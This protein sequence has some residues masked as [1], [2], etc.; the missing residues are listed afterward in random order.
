MS[1]L[2]NKNKI[3]EILINDKNIKW[4]M[5]INKVY[6]DN[7]YCFCFN[8]ELIDTD[9]RF[10]IVKLKN[11]NYVIK[12]T[13][14]NKASL[15]YNNAVEMERLLANID[16][17]GYKIIPVIPIIVTVKSDS[18]VITEY[19]GFTLQESL[20]D[21]K[22]S[23]TIPLFLFQKIFYELLT[24]GLIYRGFIPRN[25]ILKSK[26]IYM[27]DFED[28]DLRQCKDS[29]SIDL[30]Y[31]TNF[32]LNWQYFYQKEDLI[33]IIKK[34]NFVIK[35]TKELLPFEKCYKDILNI[36]DD[37]YSLR[38]KIFN[39]VINSEKPSLKHSS[40]KYKIM[41]NDLVHIM[42]DLFGDY[43]DV[44]IDLLFD[45]MRTKDESDFEM[46]L[47]LC[48]YYIKLNYNNLPKLKVNLFVLILESI[49]KIVKNKVSMN[50]NIDE[51]MF[52]KDETRILIKKFLQIVTKNQISDDN[53]KKVINAFEVIGGNCELF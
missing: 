3:N 4:E 52:N 27:I 11:K 21:I 44:I 46:F 41:P 6:K 7:K 5:I 42:A 15:E 13:T 45:Y 8:S 26:T 38:L 29:N 28:L 36:D 23:K 19:K 32:V 37:N 22:K 10:R 20:Y 49:N 39:T 48:S 12:R 14:L 43:I 24:R 34:L 33:E 40:E 53:I 30:L 18:Y 2:Y 31:L 17:D 16:I 51:I 47:N 50:D 9:D 35:E 1:S 25:I